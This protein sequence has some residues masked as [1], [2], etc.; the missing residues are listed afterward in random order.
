MPTTR[1]TKPKKKA[2]KKS[3]GRKPFRFTKENM[4]APDPPKKKK[5]APPAASRE[6]KDIKRREIETTKPQ[7]TVTVTNYPGAKG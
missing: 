6:T 1:K 5:K 4:R 3:L 7:D 2:A